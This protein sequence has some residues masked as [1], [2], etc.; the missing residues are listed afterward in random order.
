MAL[1]KCIDGSVLA[2]LKSIDGSVLALLKCIDGF[3][4][5]L[6]GFSSIFSHQNSTNGEFCWEKIEGN[7]RSANRE[8]YMHLRRANTEPSI[9]FR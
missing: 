7:L 6:L 1:L 5:A 2:F 9:D 8:P 4:L 3:I